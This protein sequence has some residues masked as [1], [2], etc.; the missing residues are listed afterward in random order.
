MGERVIF[1]VDRDGVTIE[2]GPSRGGTTAERFQGLIEDVTKD[3]GVGRLTM[4]VRCDGCGRV[5]EVREP[6]LPGGWRE[7]EDGDFCPECR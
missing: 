1:R 4:A 2:T 5:Q 3:V 6:R 7:S